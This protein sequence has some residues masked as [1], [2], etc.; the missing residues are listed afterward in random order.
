MCNC[1]SEAQVEAKAKEGGLNL[2]LN[3]NLTG[4]HQGLFR[5]IAPIT[6][7]TNQFTSKDV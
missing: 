4:S 7:S 6:I 5:F 3:L 2:N 1:A